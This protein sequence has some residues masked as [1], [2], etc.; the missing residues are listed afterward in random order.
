LLP[1]SRSFRATHEAQS[2]IRAEGNDPVV[3]EFFYK[4]GAAPD[5]AKVARAREV[6]ERELGGF[7]KE[8]RGDFL[9]GPEPTAADFTL[10]PEVGYLKRITS[11]KPESK[12]VE[13]IPAPIA[14]WAQR[15]EALPY[16]DKTFPEHW[17]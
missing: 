7:A 16:F 13:L 3:D 8:L 4:D 1:A 12:L 15:I 14:Q 17:R 5:M 11:R 2:Y 10:Y 9:A 6:I